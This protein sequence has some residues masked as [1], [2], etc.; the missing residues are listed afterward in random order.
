MTCRIGVARA[1]P[2]AAGMA[3]LAAALAGPAQTQPGAVPKT[4]SPSNPTATT[5]T[6]ENR[7]RVPITTTDGVELDGTYYRST[8]L[9][10]DS[11]CVMLVHKFGLDRAKANWNDLAT[12]L[13]GAGFAVLS[14]DLRG[15]GNSTQLSN[16]QQF[17]SIPFNRNGIRGGT[18]V[19]KKNTISSAEFKPAYLPF[20]VNDLAAARRFLEQK[21]D[22]GEVNIHSLIV[23]G[24]DAGADLGFLFT[25]AE[26][27]RNYVIGRTA[28]QS[29][30]T[31]YNAG[32]DIAAGV[33]LSL[34][35]RPAL[36]PGAPSFDISGWIRSHPVIRDKTPMAFFFG[37]G[38]RPS[39]QDS[40]AA[41][42]VLTGPMNGT[43]EK[44]KL[45]VLH[46]IKG[47]S[48]NGPG[49]LGQAGALNVTDDII[50]YCQKVMTE[51]RAIAWTEVKPEANPLDLI[52]PQRFGMRLP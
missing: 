45:D 15:H 13:Q 25:A 18:A 24:A 33:W 17:W 50:K 36:P 42:K 35:T 41:F 38:D 31:T 5:S 26:Y 43:P 51:R 29:Q 52:A 32:V 20:M 16:P 46:P 11:A 4:A 1:W 12:A 27:N 9:G 19:N 23:I 34:S 21:N 6:D 22:A 3:V 8:K 47:T 30:G 40:E 48:L 10:R 28:L 7:I 44:H 49:L 14:F 2:L 39:R 37:D